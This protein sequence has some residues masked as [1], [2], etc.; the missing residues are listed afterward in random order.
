MAVDVTVGIA[1]YPDDAT[2]QAGLLTRADAAMY[3]AKRL[4]GGRVVD[5]SD[6]GA[7]T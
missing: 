1:V 7:D 5:G 3:A 4:G 2:T 6:V